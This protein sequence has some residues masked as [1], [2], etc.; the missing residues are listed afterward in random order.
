MRIAY[1]CAAA[2][3]V[4]PVAALAKNDA[5][6]WAST[7]A[8]CHGT[9]GHSVGGNEPLA[10]MRKED[11]VRKMKDFQS[12]ARPAT[13]MH[14]ISKGYT[15]AQID[16]IAAYFVLRGAEEIGGAMS[17]TFD[18]RDFLKLSGAAAALAAAGCATNGGAKARVVVIGGG[19][20]GAT[21]A[22][23]IRLWGPSIEVVMVERQTDF[24]DHGRHHLRVQRLGTLRRAGGA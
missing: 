6:Q 5:A 12:G 4:A 8:M 18:R 15:D 2:L 14:Q 20:G 11:L 23:Y 24:E 3:A 17:K 22:K 7:C 13:V 10:G 21:A 16:Q 9:T 19:F 1:L